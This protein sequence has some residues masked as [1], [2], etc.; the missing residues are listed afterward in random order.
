MQTHYTPYL[1]YLRT[2]FPYLTLR[3]PDPGAILHN[4][5]TDLNFILP[6]FHTYPFIPILLF[7]TFIQLPSSK[8]LT[9]LTLLYTLGGRLKGA[10]GTSPNQRNIQ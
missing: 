5:G 8:G 6:S 10:Q 4:K 9:H 7:S 1:P 3:R 2:V